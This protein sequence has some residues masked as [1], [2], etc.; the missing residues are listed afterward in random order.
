[1]H[2]FLWQTVPIDLR[3]ICGN[4]GLRRGQHRYETEGCPNRRWRAGN[5][6]SQWRTSSFQLAERQPSQEVPA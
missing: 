6:E 2:S 3:P 5:G 1:M 4:C